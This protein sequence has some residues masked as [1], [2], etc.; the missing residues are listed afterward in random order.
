MQHNW[1]P[2]LQVIPL[3]R[4]EFSTDKRASVYRTDQL[5]DRLKLVGNDVVGAICDSLRA[6]ENRSVEQF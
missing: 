3:A 5:S 2:L 1:N 6:Q 4:D